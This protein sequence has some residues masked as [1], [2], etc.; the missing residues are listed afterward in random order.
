MVLYSLKL[1]HVW[2]VLI[3]LRVHCSLDGR[4]KRGQRDDARRSLL[5]GRMCSCKR[6][7]GPIAVHPLQTV[8]V[9]GPNPC[10]AA[11]VRDPI[12]VPVMLKRSMETTAKADDR[13]QLSPL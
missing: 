13:V 10:Y 4:G 5:D 6:L 3:S 11:S 2:H 1:Q 12:E 7:G 9:R 8:L